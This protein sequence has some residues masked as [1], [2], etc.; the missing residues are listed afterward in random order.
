MTRIV[1]CPAC[2][3]LWKCSDDLPETLR[4]GECR[5]T[6]SS[7]RAETLVVD[8]VALARVVAARRAPEEKKEK[9]MARIAEDL[10]SFSAR[11]EPPSTPSPEV[12]DELPPPV[13]NAKKGSNFALMMGVLGLVA[14]G[15]VAALYFHDAILSRFP[16]L[17]G[18]YET[19][20]S[21]VPCPGFAWSDVKAFQLKATLGDFSDTSRHVTIEILNTSDRPQRLPLLEVRLLNVA[22]ETLAQRLFEPADYGFSTEN[23]VAPGQTLHIEADLD[24]D[25]TLPVRGVT[26]KAV[27]PI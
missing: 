18:V 5:H 6:F 20:C 4:C 19:V 13:E 11:E 1:R 8:D 2:G 15:A 27:T 22:D 16:P 17:R 24:V 7:N 26:V 25:A 23:V 14:S 10:S 3:A 9:E 12:T 21:Q